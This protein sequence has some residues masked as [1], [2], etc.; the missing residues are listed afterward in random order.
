MPTIPPNPDPW[1]PPVPVPVDMEAY[2]PLVFK[3]RS[4]NTADLLA[5][6]NVECLFVERHDGTDPHVAGFRYLFTEADPD[7]PQSIEQA[8]DTNFA[9]LKTIGSGDRL[10]VR[11]TRW[12]GG[13]E[14]LFDG[15]AIDF[16]ADLDERSEK[17]DVYAQG[18][19]KR[20]WDGVIPGAVMRDGDDPSVVS[21]GPTDL[22]AQFNPKG[23]PNCTPAGADNYDVKNNKY[24]TFLDPLIVRK[25]DVRRFW[26][27]PNALRYLLFTEN[28]DETWVKNPDGGD[29]DLLLV[30]RVPK[31]GQVFDPLNPATY[32]TSDIILHDKPI[33]G[34]DWPTVAHSLTRDKGF[35][36]RFQ[37]FTLPSGLP[38]TRLVFNLRQA[39]PVKPLY[40]QPRFSQFDPSYSNMGA[41]RIGRDI[42]SVANRWTVQGRLV[43]YEVSLI[44]VPGFAMSA[45]DDAP[46]NL[47]NYQESSP[48]FST[49]YYDA[50][51]LYVFDETGEGHYLPGTSTKLTSVAS[52][53]GLFT[54]GKYARRRRKPIGQL[55]TRDAK[56][57]PYK[58]RLAYCNDYT[59]KTPGLWDGTGNWITIEQGKGWTLLEDRIGIR[60]TAANPN[61][62]AIGAAQGSVAD[63][64]IR[65]VEWQQPGNAR[66]FLLRLTCVI[67]SDQV[68]K[69]TATRTVSS[70]LAYDIERVVDARERYQKN[71]IDLSSIFNSTLLPIVD[72][73]DTDA[74]LAE[75]TSYR[76]SSE[77]GIL[78]GTA[79]IPYL[80]TYY[81]IGD[82]ISSV[83][84][85]GLG[86]RTDGAASTGTPVYPVVEGIRWDFIDGQRTTLFL[87]DE[88]QQRHLIER[89][90]ARS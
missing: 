85:R 72:R 90:L 30:A 88:A 40:L 35:G 3:A 38:E 41:I 13:N 51:R 1:L 84:G 22:V 61:D 74:A 9:L 69:A 16:R 68:V 21:D 4:G 33:T 64:R 20:L 56:G 57:S 27:L 32:T 79:V 8:F 86:F 63:V 15:H 24:P 17:A 19:A 36:M 71:I 12:D 59:G 14:W 49:K 23:Q 44:L 25:P 78:Q 75:A 65:G 7:A 89:K 18:V 46:L 45:G 10:L 39:G 2:P 29:L 11:V 54:R 50:Y 87:S 53:D 62:W 5:L 28:E 82:R 80:T 60:V 77:A 81:Q 73:D 47:P 55:V 48:D 52:L 26:T 67:E 34:R 42:G 83:A 58:A 43:R 31:A 37:L 6:D 76:Q 66:N 70:P